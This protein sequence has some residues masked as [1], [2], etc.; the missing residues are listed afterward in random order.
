MAWACPSSGSGDRRP[1]DIADSSTGLAHACFTCPDPQSRWKSWRTATVGAPGPILACWPGN[2]PNKPSPE[3]SRSRLQGL[4]HAL[5][6]DLPQHALAAV[7]FEQLLQLGTRIL[8]GLPQ[9]ILVVVDQVLRGQ[10]PFV[11]FA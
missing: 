7:G 9:R 6:A 2:W 4:L 1:T 8:R 5:A 3:R 10:H 11:V